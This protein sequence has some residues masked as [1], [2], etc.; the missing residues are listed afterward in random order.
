M[1]A[2][3]CTERMNTA[4]D[5]ARGHFLQNTRHENTA[6]DAAGQPARL[7]RIYPVSLFGLLYIVTADK[8]LLEFKEYEGIKIITPKQFLSI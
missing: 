8:H 5:A 7:N 4:Q 3:N 1:K 2:G 6:V